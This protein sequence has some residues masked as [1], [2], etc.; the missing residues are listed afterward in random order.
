[1]DKQKIN[2]LNQLRTLG[3][4]L[5]SRFEGPMGLRFG[6]D[7]LLGLIPVVGDLITSAISFYI[8]AQAAVL[9]CAPSTLVRMALNVMIEN[10]IDIIPLV[11]NIFDFIWKAN[12]KNLALLEN[13]LAAP[14]KVT[15]QSRVIVG[16]IALSLLVVLLGTGFIA[17]KTLFAI[18]NWITIPG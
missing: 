5:D 9:G 14:R 15:W 18:W 16:L 12:L 11:G 7:G 8:I 1:M 6:L 17:F 10:L 2:R 4:L 13:H 3:Q